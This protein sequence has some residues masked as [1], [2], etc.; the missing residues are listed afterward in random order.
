MYCIFISHQSLSNAAYSCDLGWVSLFFDYINKLFLYYYINNILYR[1]THKLTK[2]LC[3]C[4]EPLKNKIPC[5]CC[6]HTEAD[7]S[8]F[9]DYNSE[10]KEGSQINKPHEGVMTKPPVGNSVSSSNK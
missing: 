9:L 4:C 5:C 1:F 3:P 10:N 6:C 7:E 8:F 2:I